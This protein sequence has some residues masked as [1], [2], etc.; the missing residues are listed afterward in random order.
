[1]KE[2]RPLAALRLRYLVREPRVLIFTAWG[3]AYSG[4]G[5]SRVWRV[6]W[7]KHRGEK[8]IMSG[9]AVILHVLAEPGFA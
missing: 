6:K 3:P 8:K 1:M 4:G 9:R 5:W 7:E 2:R